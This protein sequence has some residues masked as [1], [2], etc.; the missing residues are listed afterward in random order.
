MIAVV[1]SSALE[2]NMKW[3]AMS[4]FFNLVDEA[5]YIS[6]LREIELKYE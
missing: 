5:V 3:S 4:R 1:A 2:P 6:K